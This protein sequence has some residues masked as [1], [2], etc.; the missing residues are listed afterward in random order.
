MAPSESP[1]PPEPS[2]PSEP[3]SEA[4]SPDPPPEL[5]SP[6]NAR[7]SST[8]KRQARFEKIWQLHQ[9]GCAISQIAAQVGVSKRTVQRILKQETFVDRQPR[10]DLDQTRRLTPFLSHLQKL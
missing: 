1:E 7:Q 4:D 8:H 9:N 5:V 10:S 2:E 3:P 6:P